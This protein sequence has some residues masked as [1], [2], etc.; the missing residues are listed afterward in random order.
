MMEIAEE[1]GEETTESGGKVLRKYNVTDILDRPTQIWRLSGHWMAAGERE[2]QDRSN[3]RAIDLNIELVGGRDDDVGEAK[4]HSW[5]MS[6]ISLNG[7][8]MTIIVHPLN[9]WGSVE[10]ISSRN[11]I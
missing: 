10:W 6:N 4:V 2:E 1:E 7:C 8:L 9:Y 5:S 3:T 11:F